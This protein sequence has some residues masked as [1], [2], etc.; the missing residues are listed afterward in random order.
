MSAL[1]SLWLPH[2]GAALVLATIV[3]AFVRRWVPGAW[4]QR[5]LFT[6]VF[7]GSL[8]PLPHFSLT[9]Y[10]RVLTG[11]LSVTALIWFS[12]LALTIPSSERNRTQQVMALATVIAA[13]ALYP[14]ALG[15][16]AFDLYA[17]GYYPTILAP[18]L[19][20]LFAFS[21]WSRSTQAAVSLGAAYV[22]FVL[23]LLESDNLWDYVLDPV[24]TVYAFSLLVIYRASWRQWLPDASQLKVLGLIAV[25]S[26][27]GFA[28]FL[29][30]R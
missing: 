16:T 24:L 19:F 20:V 4:I 13:V 18:A 15:L 23:G 8:V 3:Q 14:S 5:S 10:A 22:F 27:I 9:H 26:G 12:W 1:T 29:Q 11:D 2:L 28:I 25:C 6:A 21:V 30:L 7:L 17:H